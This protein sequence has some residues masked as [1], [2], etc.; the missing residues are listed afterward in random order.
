MSAT[1]FGVG[2]LTIWEDWAAGVRLG[3]ARSVGQWSGD[4]ELRTNPAGY[5]AGVSTIEPWGILRLHER[6]QIQA[7][8]PILLEDR[9]SGAGSESQ[10]AGG[11]GDVGAAVR[12]EV[13]SIGQY[14]GLPS[15]AFTVGGIA[16]TGQRVEETGPPLF[17]GT[18]GRGAWGAAL[19]LESEYAVVPWFVRLEVGTSWSFPFTRADTGRT[20]QYGPG[21]QLA[22]STG[23]ELVPGALVV[24]A[25]VSAEWEAPLRLDGETVPGSEARS[26]TVA[27]SVSWTL[28]PHWTV[29]ATLTDAVFPFD[30]GANRDARAGFVLG[31]RHGHF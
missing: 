17:A 14:A 16:P 2:R 4:G 12:V 29:V 25:A 19:A 20:Q 11:L 15:L 23:R 1:S 9:E 28:D 26:L 5:S 24:A 8:A 10:V 18:T 21:V 30:A 31:I 27:A 6:V 3:H 7:W 22:L 13:V